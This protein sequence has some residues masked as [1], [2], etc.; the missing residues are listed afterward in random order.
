MEKQRVSEVIEKSDA[1]VLGTYVRAPFVLARGEGMWVYDTDGRAFLDFGAGISVNNLG[2][3]DPGIAAAIAQQAAQL[4]HICN[5]YHHA[6]QA[7]LAEALCTT[8]FADK[9]YFAN[10]GAE[11]IEAAIKFA[12]KYALVTHGPGKTGIVT[13]QGAFHG[14]TAGAL[15]LTPK[16]RYQAPFRPLMPG[17]TYAPFNDCDAAREAIGPDTCA[18]FVEPVQGE[19]GIHPADPS[20][21]RAL[22]DACDEVGALLVFDEIQCGVGRTG[23]LWA[24]EQTEVTPDMLTA[25]KALGGGLPIG[26]TLLRERVAAVVE[27]GDHGSTFA[28]GPVVCRA[29]LEVLAR[30]SD[31]AFLAHVR[32]MATELIERL[33][34]L[35]SPHIV[36]I[37]GQ[38]LMIGVELDIEAAP[39]IEAGWVRGV[40][41][42][43][44]GTHV[45]RLLPPLIVE[46]E[47]I[48]TLIGTLSDILWEND[49]V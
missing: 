10:S 17:V 19:G 31:P 32:A 13:F 23:T 16:E 12:R 3:C 6:P 27:P 49:A 9:V 25:A 40:L 28:G 7:E 29:A 48:D 14:R 21:L 47:H 33:H 2:H 39:I 42:L 1:Y 36:A 35:D 37:R 4:S 34:A 38:G 30:V 22:R 41:L 20:F 24:Y 8:S 18:V 11:A 45:L 43:N 46:P 5:L 26:V 44:A 15:A